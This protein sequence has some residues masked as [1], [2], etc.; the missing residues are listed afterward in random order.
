VITP[1]ALKKDLTVIT[2]I[3]SELPDSLYGDSERIEQIILNLAGNS[4]KF[5]E[6]GGAITIVVDYKLTED[7]SVNLHFAIS[8][9]GVGIVDEAQDHIFEPFVQADN[10]I[11]RNYGGTGLGLA[12][13]HQLVEAMNGKVMLRSKVGLGT[14]FAFNVIVGQGSTCA[15]KLRVDAKLEDVNERKL[16]ILVA[17]DNLVNQ[18]LLSKLLERRGHLALVVKNGQEV[19]DLLQENS[20]DVLLLDVQMPV[21]DGITA[22]REI[23]A[24]E[25]GTDRHL[26]IIALT[27]H[28]ML[29]DRQRCLAA[30]MDDY[31]SKPIVPAEFWA[32]LDRNVN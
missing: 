31:L 19:L 32:A 14:V 25:A 12:I 27:A 2:K 13:C 10:S 3:D 24:R 21:M 26:P 15:E 7:G 28:A 5:C 18:K 17:E 20:F 1:Q 22:A 9:T 6:Q 29:E 4:V 8:D 11:S 16:K 23:R 30:G